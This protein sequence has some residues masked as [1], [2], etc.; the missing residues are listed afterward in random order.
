[1]TSL[2]A[3]AYH[4]LALKS[5]GTVWA[6]GRNYDGP[7]GDG[8]TTKSLTPVQV[9]NLSGVT[10]LAG[11]YHS[12][13]LKSDGTVWAW[14]NNEYGQLGDGTTANS[15]TPVQVKNLSGVTALAAGSHSLALKSDGTVWAWGKN[16]NGQL[17]DGTTTNRSIPVQVKGEGRPGFSGVKALVAGFVHS[18][19]VKSDGT[20]WGWGRNGSGQLGDGTTTDR[21]APV[22]VKEG[23]DGI[24]NLTVTGAKALAAG[25]SHSLALKSDG[26]VWAWGN[27]VNGPL[28][29]GTTTDRPV[30][31]Q[32]QGISDVKALAPGNFYSLALKSDGTV[33]TWGY[34]YSGQLVDGINN[35]NNY[36]PVWVPN[37]TD[38]KALA[39]GGS[40]SLALKSDGTVW[41]WGGNYYGELGDGT[42]TKRSAPVQTQG[43]SGVTALAAGNSHSLALKSDGTVWTW[44]YNYSGQLGIGTNDAAAH[45]T[46]VRVPNLSGITALAAGYDHSLALKS[47]GTVW[48]WGNNEYGQLGDGT[49]ANSS[50]PVQVKNFSGVTALALALRGHHS[51]ALK[52]DGTVWT[53]GYNYSGQLGDGTTTNSRSTPVRV[54]NLTGVTALTAGYGHSLALKSDG[55][56]WAWG[57]NVVG[58][59]GDGTTTNR[60]TPVQTQGF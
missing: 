30:P 20:V 48:A 31:V 51:L 36:T 22:Q 11:A 1:V 3:G 5:D 8:T 50:T 44:G 47:D 23:Q 56:V 57:E 16:E 45:T 7:L 34:N 4:S 15:F 26:T 49:T 2:G 35:F 43:I 59:L 25:N 58:Q 46:P 55:T 38:V 9:K 24:G 18:L 29:D 52:S 60:L 32:T 28:G 33:W 41:A 27:N 19:A 14:G 17:G 40:H 21:S 53:W 10:A 42:T 13:A 37:L 54:L 39:S 6:W 12:L